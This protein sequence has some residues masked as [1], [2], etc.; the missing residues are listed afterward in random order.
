MII[1]GI[2]ARV[3]PPDA[4]MQIEQIG[5]MLALRGL[6]GRSG[7]ADGAD[8]AFARGFAV[9]NPSLLKVYPGKVGH[10]VEWQQ[11]AAQYHPNWEACDDTAR[12]LH[13]R[14]S[15]I[16]LGDTPISAPEPVNAVVCWTEGGAIKGGTGQA[17]RIATALGISVFNL[18]I[19]TPDHFWQWIDGQ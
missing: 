2:G 19:V 15:A 12:K 6:R 7:G 1:A 10:Y 4:L 16:M 5:M 11:H 8:S 3:T 9:I 13:A 18:A 17:L 14:N